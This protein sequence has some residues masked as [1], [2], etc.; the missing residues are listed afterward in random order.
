MSSTVPGSVCVCVC[1][2][3][4]PPEV[5][6]TCQE[7]PALPACMLRP[8]WNIFPNQEAQVTRGVAVEL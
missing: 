1:A 3:P 7:G 4:Q 5:V 2:H 8:G 6:S